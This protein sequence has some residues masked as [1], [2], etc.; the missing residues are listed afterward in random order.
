MPSVRP[1][2]ILFPNPCRKLLRLTVKPIPSCL[3]GDFL[4]V[5]KISITQITIT[6]KEKSYS[7]SA[8]S[9][10]CTNWT[11][12]TQKEKSIYSFLFQT[13][14]LFWGIIIL[15]LFKS[16]LTKK[17]ERN[18]SLLHS[19]TQTFSLFFENSHFTF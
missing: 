10:N 2:K 3:R 11:T 13:K 19:N 5:T 7:F 15:L 17:E 16:N 12:T 14:S 6:K 4:S 8:H 1:S 9:V 18:F